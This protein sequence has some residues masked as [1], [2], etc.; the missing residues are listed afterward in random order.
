MLLPRREA[1]EPHCCVC[2]IPQGEVPCNN[3][4]TTSVSFR[5]AFCIISRFKLHHMGCPSHVCVGSVPSM[6]TP[7]AFVI[8]GVFYFRLNR[9]TAA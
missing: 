5:F 9:I 2:P 1:A 6:A 4:R 8:R 3:S 7:T